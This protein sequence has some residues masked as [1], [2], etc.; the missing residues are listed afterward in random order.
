MSMRSDKDVAVING[1][2]AVLFEKN[3]SETVSRH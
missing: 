1:E 2:R 3:V